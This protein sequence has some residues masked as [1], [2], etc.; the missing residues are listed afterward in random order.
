MMEQQ[1]NGIEDPGASLARAASRG[2]LAQV[3]LLLDAGAD[4]RAKDRHGSTALFY[5][6]GAG[7][8]EIARLLLE[9]GADPEASNVVGMT[10]HAVA[11]SRGHAQLAALIESHKTGG[12]SGGVEG[13]LDRGRPALLRAAREGDA[14]G[15]RRLLEA[16]AD[17]DTR[18]ESA[19]TPL[20][21]AAVGGHTEAVGMLLAGG[22]QPNA[23]N[24]KGWTPLM[25]AVSLGDAGLA[26]ALLDAGA[27]PNVRDNEGLTP[28]MQAVGEN[29]VECARLLL[30][31]GADAGLTNHSGETA[32]SIAAR[33]A[34][35]EVLQ[36]FGETE[37]HNADA[38]TPAF[39]LTSP[40]QLFRTEW[41][42]E[43][44]TEPSARDA[45]PGGAAVP[46]EVEATSESQSLVPAQSAPES[47]ERLIM[48][49]EAMRQQRPAAP[50]A[51]IAHKLMLT[52][53]EAAALT[54][55]SQRRLREAIRAGQLK[56]QIIGRGWRI[57]RTDLEDYVR[58][59]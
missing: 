6:A 7:H 4:P 38:A 33:H 12:R 57:K 8:Y 27:D 37:T 2:E 56:A 59:L 40:E 46:A 9:G 53:Q 3:R 51:D 48:A 23:R 41:V 14:A 32:Q 44:D 5:A 31:R 19:W 10:P 26:R 39:D 34:F 42:G 28:L 30:E 58:D 18:D 52:L 55:L 21:L 43:P 25:L 1:A 36:L 47:V 54:G 50:L 45:E 17:A 35:P 16:G 49:L 13:A 24:D 20:M 11:T 22:A 29:N 15:V